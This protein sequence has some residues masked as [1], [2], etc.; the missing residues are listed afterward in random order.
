MCLTRIGLAR[1]ETVCACGSGATSG[2]FC[3]VSA[4]WMAKLMRNPAPLQRM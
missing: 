3:A 2:P 4:P 1:R